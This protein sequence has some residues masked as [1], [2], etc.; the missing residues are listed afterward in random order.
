[1]NSQIIMKFALGILLFLSICIWNVKAKIST[2][3]N[4]P[5]T[6]QN[7]SLISRIEHIHS[8]L[9]P[10]NFIQRVVTKSK[11]SKR[12]KAY[13]L[14]TPEEEERLLKLKK[15]KLPWSEIV[16][17]FPERSIKSLKNKYRRL[18][19]KFLAS[20][21]TTE[22]DKLLVKLR[23]SN[24]PWEEIVT[25]FDNRSIKSLEERFA[26][27]TSPLR[28]YT[29]KEDRLILRALNSGKTVAETA[30]LLGRGKG[31]VKNRIRKLKESHQFNLAPELTRNR[32]YTTVEFELMHEL[33]EDNMSWKLIAKR[34]PGR[35]SKGL[36]LAFKKYQEKQ[37]RG[38]QND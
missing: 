20:E 19:S 14:W 36:R 11:L 17:S 3:V 18:Q 28:R 21:W 5:N 33:R 1:M 12:A 8:D 2:Q 27:L 35:S 29:S 15:Q 13:K 31:S 30:Q 10:V 26:S 32:P 38:K 23:E 24:T 7:Y 4:F 16:N 22:E 9:S 25:Y 34:F 37:Q 6:R